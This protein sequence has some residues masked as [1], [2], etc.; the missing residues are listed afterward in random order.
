MKDVGMSTLQDTLYA[1]SFK[2]IAKML[3]ENISRSESGMC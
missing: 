3:M 1:Q 2:V